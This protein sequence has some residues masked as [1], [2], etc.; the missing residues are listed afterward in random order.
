MA[1]LCCPVERFGDVLRH[2]SAADEPVTARVHFTLTGDDL[3]QLAELSFTP[4][5]VLETADQIESKGGGLAG[6]TE[7]SYASA[8]GPGLLT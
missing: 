3:R 7:G 4:P 2:L 1:A 6:G 5:P 8:Q